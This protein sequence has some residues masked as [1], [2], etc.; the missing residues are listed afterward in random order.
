[1]TA[2]RPELILAEF[3]R[4]RDANPD[5]ALEAV[6]VA[7]LVEDAFGITLSDGQIDPAVLCDPGSRRTLI[8]GST[9]PR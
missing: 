9:T 1:M 2:L 6:R 7:L 4:L 8:V 3:A 5:P